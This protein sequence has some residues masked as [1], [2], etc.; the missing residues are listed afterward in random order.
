VALGAA[1]G[2]IVGSAIALRIGDE[3]VEVMRRAVERVIG[4]E[5]G[6]KLELLLQ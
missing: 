6:P 2:F 1:L 4:H 5:D 3:G